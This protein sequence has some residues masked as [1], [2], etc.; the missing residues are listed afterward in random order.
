[1]DADIL[2][3]ILERQFVGIVDFGKIVCADLVQLGVLVNREVG[4]CYTLDF[5]AALV[6]VAY[7]N[8]SALLVAIAN[9]LDCRIWV[10][11]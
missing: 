7:C 5:A 2:Q 1:M 6:V 3:G 11:L 9:H 10:F 4:V 8:R